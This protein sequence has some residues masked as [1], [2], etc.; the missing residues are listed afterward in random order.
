MVLGTAASASLFGA[1]AGP[2][3]GGGV[4]SLFGL[5]ASFIATALLFALTLAWVYRVARDPE[6]TA[7]DITA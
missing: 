6:I 1:F 3:V 2:L 4:A 7:P 5:R